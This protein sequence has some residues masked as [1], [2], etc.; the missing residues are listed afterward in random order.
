[1]DLLRGQALRQGKGLPLSYDI[2]INVHLA[3]KASGRIPR[4]LTVAHKQ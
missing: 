3:L 2:E 4:R 1:V